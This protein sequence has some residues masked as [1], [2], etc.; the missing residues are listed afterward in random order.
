MLYDFYTSTGGIVNPVT[1]GTYFVQISTSTD[2]TPVSVSVTIKAAGGAISSTTLTATS[3][4]A[5]APSDYEFQFQATNGL[6]SGATITVVYPT[7]FNVAAATKTSLNTSGY[8]MIQ[9][10]TGQTITYKV[11]T[12]AAVSTGNMLYD[13]YTS[14][15]GIVNPVTPGT[16]FVQISTSTD[17]TP[18]SVPVIITQTPQ[19]LYYSL[20]LS[21]AGTGGGDINGGMSCSKG[22]SC[23]SVLFA[24][25]TKVTLMPTHDSNS[26][27]VG[28]SSECN[29]SGNNCEVTMN[30]AKSVTVTFSP[31]DKVRIFSKPYPTLQAAYDVASDN[32]VILMLDG[33]DAGPL[34][35]NRS[36]TVT[37]S[38]GY[39]AAYTTQT[40]STDLL[41]KVTLQKGTAIFDRVIVR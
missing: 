5:G 20:T 38:G 14:T 33:I 13:F 28:W 36:V 19:P 8:I 21:F 30:K 24:E 17:P 15:G 7:G 35:A 27:F 37:I 9:S 10:V 22:K 16:Y 6:P 34:T 12:S 1:P 2:P 25:N 31:A 3:L 32:A 18:V 11:G 40:G 29:L 23:P 4:M 26:V 41:G 39:N